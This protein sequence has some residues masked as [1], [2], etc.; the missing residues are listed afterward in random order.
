MNKSIK[1]KRDGNVYYPYPYYPVGFFYITDSDISPASIYGGTWELIKDKF[2]LG[3]GDT[4]EL[5][6]TG[7]E[8]NHTLTV[9]E[10]AEHGHSTYN[11]G[12][13]GYP[14]RIA[15]VAGSGEGDSLC[16]TMPAGG[17]QPHNNMP[18]Y[19]SV[20]IWHRIA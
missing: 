12:G 2:L 10:L 6:A 11:N 5:G 18:P 7:G 3:C 8:I 9:A 4:F 15:Q 13:N 14:Y 16:M 17:N 20:Y 19:L 1:F